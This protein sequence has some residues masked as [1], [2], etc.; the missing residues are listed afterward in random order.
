MEIFETSSQNLDP[1]LCIAATDRHF[2]FEAST[3]Q[4][5]R[6]QGM[7]FCARDQPFYVLFGAREIAD[8]QEYGNTPN[9]CNAKRQRMVHRCSVA[10]RLASTRH[11]LGRMALQPQIPRQ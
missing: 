5:V 10:D 6:R 8:P 4:N 7:G 1:A 2:P 3:D 9:Q 11:G